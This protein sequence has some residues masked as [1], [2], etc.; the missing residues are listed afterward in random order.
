MRTAIGVFA[1]ACA[2]ARIPV[3]MADIECGTSLNSGL[4]A[5]TSDGHSC[6]RNSDCA[7]GESCMD[8]FCVNAAT[9]GQV[10]GLGWNAPD[11]ALVLTKMTPGRDAILAVI[12]ALGEN[13]SH[14]MLSHG[15]TGWASHN[16]AKV[17]GPADL[18]PNIM[19]CRD[20]LS[21]D[22][23][24]YGHPGAREIRQGAMWG[25]LYA[26][27]ENPP[28]QLTYQQ[29][30]GCWFPYPG[31]RFPI[32]G[33]TPSGAEV[34]AWERLRAPKRAVP[35]GHG[36][37]M[38]QILNDNGKD[39][40]YSF[41]Q[42]MDAGTIPYGNSASEPNGG[43]VCS[44][45]AAYLEAKAGLTPTNP[46]TYSHAQLQAAANALRSN[47]YDSLN[48]DTTVSAILGCLADSC[49]FPPGCIQF[50]WATAAPFVP[51][52]PPDFA[53]VALGMGGCCNFDNGNALKWNIANQVANCMGVDRCDYG[54]Q[55]AWM[56]VYNN[57]S[58]QPKSITPDRIGGWGP[59][60][61]GASIWSYDI[62][63]PVQWNGPG[64][65]YGCWY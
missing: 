27:S 21:G 18:N 41:Y 25:F 23:L 53:G 26:D 44:T 58:A 12:A 50:G 40:V 56:Q 60:H 36:G 1:A 39:L 64:N 20:V 52:L 54:G 61:T 63:H 17:P 13:Y 24:K 16:T 51:L 15:A 65:V 2:L 37:T 8:G 7:G 35:D 32:C 47:I 55:D 5:P 46:F 48:Q 19:M 62:A 29:T 31:A 45:Y 59:N 34:T 49:W 42:Y 33:V 57:P 6:L 28:T 30:L 11:G 10:N 14:T 3:A 38:Y 9:A 22:V 4:G 43:T